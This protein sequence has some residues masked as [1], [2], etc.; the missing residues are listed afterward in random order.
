M[1]NKRK[2]FFFL[3]HS[4]DRIYFNSFNLDFIVFGFSVK[5]TYKQTRG[6]CK[7][8]VKKDKVESND[9]NIHKHK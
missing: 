2:I 5:S 4:I 7:R 1:I 3:E 9:D 6:Y 8:C